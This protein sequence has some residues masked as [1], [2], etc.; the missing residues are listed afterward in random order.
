LGHMPSGTAHRAVWCPSVA[1]GLTRRAVRRPGEVAAIEP[2]PGR[3][4]DR[5]LHGRERLDVDM[6]DA[7]A[8]PTHQMRSDIV[9]EVVHGTPMIDVDVA[10]HAEIG[11]RVERAVHGRHVNLRRHGGDVLGHVLGR[12]VRLGVD[13][14]LEHE[15]PLVCDPAAG[16][17][18]PIER[19][20][21]I[22]VV[23]HRRSTV[24]A[25]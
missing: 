12:R 17:S 10:D 22:C 2:E 4:L 15:A 13:E 1:G 23:H 19:V 11:Q 7:A 24:P 18:E 3:R 5:G 25:L 21:H 20:G 6:V 9:G 8:P 14:C 16:T